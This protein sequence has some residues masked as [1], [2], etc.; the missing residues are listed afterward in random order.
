[1]RDVAPLRRHASCTTSPPSAAS[2]PRPTSSTSSR[3]ASR[4]TR[5]SARWPTPSSCRTSRV[6]T[7]GG[8]LKH[9]VLLL[10]GPNTYLPFLQE[11]W[12]LRIPQTW[13]ERGYEYPKDV[14]DRGAHLRPRERAVL[15]GARRGALR[16]ARGRRASA[17]SRRSTRCD[18]YITHGPQGAPRRDAPAR[19]WRRRRTSSTSSA[20]STRIPKFEPG[21]VRAGARSCAPSSAS[22]AARRRRRRCSSTTRRQ[23]PL[24]GLPALEGQPDPGHEGAPRAAPRLRRGRPEGA[25]SRSWASARPATRPTC[26]R[27]AS[28]SR[29]EH[30]RDGRAHDERRALLRRRRRHLRHRRAG[31]QGPVHEERRHR[32]LPPVEQLLGRQRHAAAGDG[33]LVRRARSPSSPTSR[34]RPSSRRSSRYGCA[35][36]LDTDRVNF[37]KEGFSKEEMLA[38]LAQ[39]LPKNVWQYVVQIPRLAALGTKF[40]LQGGTQYNLAAVK[41][42][43]DYIKERV[44]GARGVRPPAHRRGGRH[45]RGDGDAARRQAQGHVDASSASMRRSTSSTRPKNDD[46][47]RLPLLPEQLQA[48]VHRHDAAPTASTSRYIA[49]FSLREGHGRDRRRRC[50]RSSSERKKIAKE[51]PNLVDYEAKRAFMHFY[52]TRADARGRLADRTTSRSRRASSACAA[53]RSTRPFQRSSQGALGRARARCASA[54]RACSTSTRRRRSSGRTSRRSASRSR[55]S[56]SATRPPRRCGSRAASTASIDPCFPCK[57]AQAHIH[58]LL[59]HQHREKKPLKYIFFPILTHVPNF[60]SSTRWTTRAAPSSP[61]RRTS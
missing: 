23:D 46:E 26:S 13:D 48:H 2:S 3:A 40:V 54:S 60:G 14:P 34:S 12:R 55:T 29:R 36:F 6:L 33:R 57:V 16:P 61:A 45:R 10:G 43:V 44:P 30:R 49:G 24:Q 1:M 4:R 32:Q 28:R 25:S 11:C 38:G 51:F 21:D 7:R 15:R 42:Q 59:F 35:V 19:R 20:S 37:Q 31:H 8:T 39:V 50:W 58:N 18:E 53:S 9:R 27:S 56:S 52:D 5:S 22:T 47:T 41:A 17:S